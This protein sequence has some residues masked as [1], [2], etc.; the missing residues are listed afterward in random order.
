MRPQVLKLDVSGIPEGWITLEDAAH[1]Y[2]SDGVSWTIGD[3]CAVMRGGF[4]RLTGLQSTLS[5]HPIVASN[6]RS[7]SAA[8]AQPPKLGRTNAKLF[9]RDRYTCAYC[10]VRFRDSELTREHITPTS[11][12]GLDVWGNVASACKPC[13]GRKDCRTPEEARMPLLYVPYTPSRWEDMLLSG[14]NVLAD[15]HDFLR[16]RLAPGS[17]L[18]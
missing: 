7:N 2:A 5:V 4:A 16:S 18:L 6:G 15:Q 8:L 11:R 14:R 12:G 3:P 1:L 17:R 13:N 9:R 10:G